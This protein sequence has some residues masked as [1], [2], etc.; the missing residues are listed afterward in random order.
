MLQLRSPGLPELAMAWRFWLVVVSTS[1]PFDATPSQFAKPVLQ[2]P[3][4]QTPL[5]QVSLAFG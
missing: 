3:R 4:V 5:L 1:H 2:A